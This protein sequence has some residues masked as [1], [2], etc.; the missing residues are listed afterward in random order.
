MV[1]LSGKRIKLHDYLSFRRD[2][3]VDRVSLEI[4]LFGDGGCRVAEECVNALKK[5][6]E[7]KQN[8]V[9]AIYY[10]HSNAIVNNYFTGRCC[11]LLSDKYETI[12]MQVSSEECIA[13]TSKH[14]SVGRRFKP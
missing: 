13:I 1:Y 11:F 3:D 5:H 2:G 12:A 4:N 7:G 14:Y 10:P 6:I 9:L 8:K